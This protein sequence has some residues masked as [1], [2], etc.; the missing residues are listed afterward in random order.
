MLRMHIKH[1]TTSLAHDTPHK[2]RRQQWTKRNS[3][4]SEAL[5]RATT[6]RLVWQGD[7]DCAHDEA[8]EH[9][10]CGEGFDASK[11]IYE[12]TIYPETMEM[13]L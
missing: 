7:K 5:K 12:Q 10:I 4:P 13:E 9:R 11:R 2:T 6:N 8:R 3:L 1:T